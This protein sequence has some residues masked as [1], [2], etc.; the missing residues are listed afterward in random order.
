MK[1]MIFASGCLIACT[2]F[3][4]SSQTF[5]RPMGLYCSCPPTTGNGFGSVVPSVAQLEHVDGVLVRIGWND[6]ESTPGVY[7]WTLLDE[8]IA[9]AQ[10][11]DIKI[12]LSIINGPMA[13]NWLE[14][15]GVDFFDY[16]LQGTPR[17]LPIP[18]DAV[19]Q[20]RWMQFV[21]DLGA[22]YEN[23]E[24]IS[25]VYITNSSGNGFEM[26]L[27]RSP[28]D[29][30]NWLNRGYTDQMYAQTWKDAIDAFAIAFPNHALSHEVHPVLGSDV[31]AEDVYAHARQL[32]GNRVGVLAAWWMVHN[33]ID[34]YPGMFELLQD[35]S[36]TSHSEVQVAN[37][38]TNTP[39][40]F[41]D[42]GYQGEIDLAIESGVR[43][44]EVWN[45]DLLNSS[46]T[47]I[48]IDTAAR[49]NTQFCGKSDINEDGL[50]NF[51]DVSAFLSAFTAMEIA[52]DFNDDGSWNFF[53][54]SDF[55]SAFSA[56]CP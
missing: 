48:M 36:Y 15:M 22:R 10:S 4:A 21:A 55:L 53:D 9:S 38:F 49:L 1:N 43:Y 54:I 29:T 19:H 8:Q 45:S 47:E 39:E 14:D 28:T 25:L 41:S 23:E 17:R 12:S 11:F 35:A 5:D 33:A 42:Q 50:L 31:V 16:E 24:T 32:H 2:S 40:R 26:Q 34:V 6:I 20:S 3:I 52:A 44:M 56:G 13:P 7:D 37:S 30:Q 18:W 51:F 46:L 27:P